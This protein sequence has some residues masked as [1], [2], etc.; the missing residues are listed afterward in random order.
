MSSIYELE[1]LVEDS[2]YFLDEYFRSIIHKIDIKTEEEKLETPEKAN[3]FNKERE[4]LLERIKELQDECKETLKEEVFKEEIE[5]IRH[6]MTTFDSKEEN[7]QQ[8]LEENINLMKSILLRFHTY[9]FEEGRSDNKVY[10]EV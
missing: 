2:D 4:K 5:K 8:K 10:A 6:F 7:S 3:K 9:H 1:N